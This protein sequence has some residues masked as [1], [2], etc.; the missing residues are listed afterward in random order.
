MS[1]S[2]QAIEAVKLLGDWAKWL[3]TIE[4]AAIAS[5]GFG[6]TVK[7]AYTQGMIRAFAAAAVFFFT[8]SISA[9]A[10]LLLTLP[11]IAQKIESDQ[12]IWTTSDESGLSLGFSTRSLVTVE[13]I[14]FALG[15]VCI[16]LLVVLKVL[17]S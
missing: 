4:I 3:I 10:L 2:G 5:I 15:I 12:N 7:D 17:W 8:L 9:A 6:T 14:F 16:A 13:S 1:E 11:G